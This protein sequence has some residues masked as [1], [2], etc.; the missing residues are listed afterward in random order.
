MNSRFTIRKAIRIVKQEK[1]MLV[2]LCYVCNSFLCVTD[3]FY[4]ISLKE[5]HTRSS[6]LYANAV[7]E[8]I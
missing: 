8:N 6:L 2:I 5:T 1:T 7:S 4:C 3:A